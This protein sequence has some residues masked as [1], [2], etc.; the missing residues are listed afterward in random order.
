MKE[1]EEMIRRAIED[2]ESEI[3]AYIRLASMAG[4]ED[5]RRVLLSIAEDSI[6]HSEVLKGL[7]RALER[8][9]GLRR[10]L[11]KEHGDLVGE[12]RTHLSIELL[13]GTVYSDMLSYADVGSLKAV[14]E[15]LE[16]EEERHAKMVK[17]LIKML[18]KAS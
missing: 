17:G 4:K 1:L 15:T 12:L 9:R 6:V 5:V 7:L 10:R 3:A 8:I 13:A 14:L 16:R 11:A 2:E 18:E